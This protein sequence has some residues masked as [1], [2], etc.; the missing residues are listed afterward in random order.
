MNKKVLF[1]LAAALMSLFEH[2]R[3]H[4]SEQTILFW[5]CRQIEGGYVFFLPPNE[6]GEVRMLKIAKT[7]KDFAVFYDVPPAEMMWVRVKA[8]KDYYGK[9]SRTIRELHLW[10]TAQISHWGP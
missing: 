4:V 8:R 10:P 5:D 1:L 2:S 9:E 3:T 6:V 7:E